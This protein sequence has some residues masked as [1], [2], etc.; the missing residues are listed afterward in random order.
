MGF[1]KA[2]YYLVLNAFNYHIPKISGKISIITFPDYDDQCRAILEQRKENNFYILVEDIRVPPPIFIGDNAIIVKRKSIHGLYTIVT[3][4]TL[5]LTHGLSEK[6]K[7]LNKKQQI[8]INITHGMYLKKMHLLL[9]ECNVTPNFHYVFSVSE[10]HREILSEMFGLHIK[11]IVVKGLPRNGLLKQKSKNNTLVDLKEKFSKIHVWLPTY[12][13]SNTEYS[14]VDVETDSL[15]GNSTLN[16]E[17]LDET[18]KK[19]NEY[20]I[21]KP[22]PMAKY[23]FPHKVLSNIK[24]ES[25]SDSLL[26]GYSLYELLSAVDVL[27]TDYSSVFIDFMITKKPIIFVM[28]DA[29]DYE[30]NRGL[31]F[32]TE[33]NILPGSIIKTSEQLY[34]VIEKDSYIKNYELC[35]YVDKSFCDNLINDIETLRH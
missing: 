18:L 1:V 6:F 11:K 4:R 26:N 24:I 32:C 14:R 10:M 29:K 16:L 13:K 15:F 8:V 27:W 21:I 34:E 9:D 19:N 33:K 17:L 2:I 23:V 28:F 12:R 31:T 35:P 3:S 7:L 5:I 30:S 25:N 20:L 22:H